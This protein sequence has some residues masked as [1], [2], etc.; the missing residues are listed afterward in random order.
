MKLSS[1]SPGDIVS[2]Y[3][4]ETGPPIQSEPVQEGSDTTE[5]T[6]LDFGANERIIYVTLTSPGLDESRRMS[7]PVISEANYTELSTTIANAFT[8]KEV[9]GTLSVGDAVYLQSNPLQVFPNDL[10]INIKSLEYY[11]PTSVSDAVYLYNNYSNIL[12]FGYNGTNEP[13]KYKVTLELRRGFATTTKEFVLTVP[14]V[15]SALQ[16]S[17]N[18]AYVLLNGG[19]IDTA[20]QEAMDNANEVLNNPNATVQEYLTALI[21]IH[22]ALDAVAGE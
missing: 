21:A 6:G 2:V 14:T 16:Q 13:I 11:S 9:P 18:A 19:L 1:L 10:V 20:L 3:T 12:Y 5:I 17:A 15:F 8:D 4:N 7:V 22:S